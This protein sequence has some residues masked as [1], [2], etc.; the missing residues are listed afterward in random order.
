[1]SSEYKEKEIKVLDVNV[2][3][4]K[5]ALEYMGAKKVFDNERTFITFDDENNSFQSKNKII[6]LTDEGKL[7]LSIS[8]LDS[9]GQKETIKLFTSREKETTDF[10]NQLGVVPIAKVESNRISYE[11]DGIDFDIDIFPHIPPFLEIDLENLD[12][13]VTDLLKKLNLESNRVV[14]MGTEDIFRELGFDYF[15]IFKIN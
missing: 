6:R 10:L 13:P 2:E 4:L 7:K 15:D 8:Y 5:K 14:E 1:M 12:Y 3:E 11:L 9:S